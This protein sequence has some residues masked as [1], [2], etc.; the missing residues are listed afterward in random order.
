MI[1]ERQ[2][3]TLH[4]ALVAS[5][6]EWINPIPMSDNRPFEHHLKRKRPSVRITSS[7]HISPAKTD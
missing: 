2:S 4:R 5:M 7:P 3:D 1:D 6:D